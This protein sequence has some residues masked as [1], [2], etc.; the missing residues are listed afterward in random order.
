[1]PEYEITLPTLHAGQVTAFNSIRGEKRAALRC[2]RR[3]GKTTLVATI[4]ADYNARGRKVGFFAPDYKMVSETYLEIFHLLEPIVANSH[5][6]EGVI[7]CITGG[8]VDF[9]TLNNPRAGRSRAYHLAI[10]DEGAFGPP[11]MMDIWEQAI[12]PTLLDY[13]GTC[14]VCSNTN[15]ADPANF[16][17]RICNEPEHGFVEFHARSADNPL[18]PAKEI[19]RLKVVKPPLVF[20]QEYD[21][22]FVDWSGVSFFSEQKLLVDGL[23]VPLPSICDTVISV[24]DT[25]VKDGKE[26]DG[27]AVS[28]WAFSRFLGIPLVC[29]DW[30]IVQIQGDL[31]IEWLPS[32]LARGEELARQCGARYGYAGAWIEDAQSGSILLQQGQRRSYKVNAIATTLVAAGKDGRALS[33]SGYVHQDMVKFSD[34][35]YHK[36]AVFKGVSRNHMLGQVCGY[37]IGDK[38]A[39][40]RADDL[41]DTF[42]YAISLTLGDADGH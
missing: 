23:P 36:T 35:A 30:D 9:W 10:I 22:E 34:Y 26:N 39:Y 6:G 12:E 3:F 2:G 17:W 16:F 40:K 14:L 19:E 20:A 24:I 5:K 27:T 25:A 28:H 21:A 32:V 4:A 18:L 29:L 42:T 37:R 8:R 31:L 38:D 15:G 1:M 13:E 11:E 41:A 33:V 7:R